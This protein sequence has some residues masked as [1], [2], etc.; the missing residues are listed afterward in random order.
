MPSVCLNCG[1]ENPDGARFCLNC[2]TPFRHGDASRADVH[3]ERKLATVLFADLVGSTSM[4]DEQ[5]D[6]ERT[7]QMLNRFY[8]AMT[9]VVGQYGGT[10]E[11][12]AG[13]ASWLHSVLRQPWRTM[14]NGSPRGARDA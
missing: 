6:P 11:K 5:A 12:F 2:A 8:D 3:E 13:D 4:A 10:V 14:P 7:R 1:A 9:D